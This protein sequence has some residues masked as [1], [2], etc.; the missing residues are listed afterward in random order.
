MTRDRLA[1]SLAAVLAV[2]CIYYRGSV[3]AVLAFALP[4]A[5]HELSHL[6]AIRLLGLKLLALRAEPQGL[7]IRYRGRCSDKGCLAVA[8]AGPC[9]GFLYAVCAGVMGKAEWL[10]RSAELSVLLSAFNLLP[11]LPL[12]GGRVFS[13]LCLMQL[14]TDAGTQLYRAVS[15]LLLAAVLLAGAVSAYWLHASAPLAAG[16]WLLLFQNEGNPLEKSGNI[17]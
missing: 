9:G 7:C 14:G 8:L 12:D 2:L 15:T 13:Q 16:I 5:A 3:E 11:I 1:C 10:A 17:L 4:V 6:L